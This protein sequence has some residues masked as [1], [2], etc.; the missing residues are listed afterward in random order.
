MGQP[1]FS[2]EEIARRGEEL[3]ARSIRAKDVHLQ[4]VDGGL[5]TVE[6]L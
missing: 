2:D 6:P 5:V 3:Y 1:R 4:V